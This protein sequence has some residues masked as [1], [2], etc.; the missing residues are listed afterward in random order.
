MT[1]ILLQLTQRLFQGTNESHGMDLVALN[2]QR[3]RDHGLPPYLEWRKICKL[4][5]ISTW[6]QLVP[7]VSEP[8]VTHSF[9]MTQWTVFQNL[10]KFNSLNLATVPLAIESHIFPAVVSLSSFG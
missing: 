4:P 3:G 7:L 8:Q 10:L 9:S 1:S 2:V 5:K 6:K